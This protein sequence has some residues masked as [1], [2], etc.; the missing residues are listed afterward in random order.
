[1]F[2]RIYDFIKITIP[3]F[4]KNIWRFR[5]ELGNH[6]WWDYSHTLSLMKRSLQLTRDGLESKGNEVIE[7]RSKKIQKID[8]AI[9]LIDLFIEDDFTELAMEDLKIEKRPIHS[10]VKLEDGRFTIETDN[11]EDWD[12]IFQRSEKIKRDMWD[13]LWNIFKGTK[14]R[15]GSDLRGW[16][17]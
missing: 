15:D 4:F 5:K 10:L 17:D 2:Y 1:M 7:E 9:Y 6:Q 12:K 11:P 13:E 8:R 14:K 3:N 16:W